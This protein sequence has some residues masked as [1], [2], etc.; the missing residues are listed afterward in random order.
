[1][2]PIALA[3][4]SAGCAN[5]HMEWHDTSLLRSNEFSEDTIPALNE[6]ANSTSNT[7]EDRGRAIFTL[8]GRYLQPGCSSSELR[9][10]LTDVGW[11]KDSELQR[12]GTWSGWIPISYPFED[13]EFC[14]C[15]FPTGPDKRAN[16]WHVYFRLTGQQEKADALRFLRGSASA[17]SGTKMAEFALCFPHTIYPDRATGRIERFSAQG[18]HV[19]EEWSR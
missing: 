10:V 17:G 9:Q 7:Q 11:L 3:F 12:L 16:E 18:I 5:D 1:M 4:I 19:Y 15:L 2:L 8:F 13:T 14:L 6:T